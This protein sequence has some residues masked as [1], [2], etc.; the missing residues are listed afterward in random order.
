MKKYDIFPT[1]DNLK[2]SIDKDITGRN[3]DIFYLLKLLNLQDGSWS[4]AI[5]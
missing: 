5:P 1:E 3:K 4:I 2:M